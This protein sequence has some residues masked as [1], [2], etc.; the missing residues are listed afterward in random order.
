[1]VLSN[2]STAFVLGF[3]TPL[4]AVCVLPLY[5][6]FLAF[7][8]SKYSRNYKKQS[9]VIFG[10]LVSFGVILS[11]SLVGIIFS[12]ILKSSLTNVISILS[13]VAFFILA[14]ISL[15]MIIGKD[16]WMY[17][18]KVKMPTSK[19]S[20]VHALLFGLFFGA[21]V[22]PCNPAFIAAL[23]AGVISVSSFA[24]NMVSFIAFGFGM[25]AP[26]LIFSII[27]ASASTQIIALLS[28]NQRK[29]NFVAGLIMLIVSIYYLF[30]VFRVFGGL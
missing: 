6:G 19:N 23:F 15:F 8:S 9:F 5:P 20:Y 28:K 22:L 12:T 18:P 2:I 3:L 25:S 24:T 30:F 10:V 21:I 4:G 1:M 7:L 17:I 13:P 29:I 26:L 14:I 16:P 27:S 11:M